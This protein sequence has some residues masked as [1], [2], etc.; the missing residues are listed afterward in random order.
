M[1]FD[2]FRQALRAFLLSLVQWLD[3]NQPLKWQMGLQ[4]YAL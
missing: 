4:K 2:P 3:V 1:Y